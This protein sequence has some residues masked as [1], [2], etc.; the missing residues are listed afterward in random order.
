MSQPGRLPHTRRRHASTYALTTWA[1][2]AESEV[3]SQQELWPRPATG[4]PAE[5]GGGLLCFMLFCFGLATCVELW[6]LNTPITALTTVEGVLTAGGRLAGLVAG[7]ALL[8]QILLMSLLVVLGVSSIRAMRRR[9]RT[10]C[11]VGCI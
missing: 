3:E 4:R 5:D 10:R 9:C 1:T 8:M 6:W 11:G 2:P 7:V